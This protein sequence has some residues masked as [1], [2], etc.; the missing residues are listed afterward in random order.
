MKIAGDRSFAIFSLV[1]LA[2]SSAACRGGARAG[3]GGGPGTGGAGGGSGPGGTDAGSPVDSSSPGDATDGAASLSPDE[4]CRAA[5]EVQC[6]RLVTC[7][8]GGDPDSCIAESRGYAC[9]D[10]YFNADTE[11]TVANITACLADLANLPCTDVILGAR[12]ACF[13]AG[14]RAAGEGCAY[15]SQCRSGSCV[16][17]LTECG[18]CVV[19]AGSG[20]ACGTLETGAC[21]PGEFCHRTTKLCTP[22]GSIVHAA[23][24]QP[25]DLS[26]SPVVGCMGDLLCDTPSGATTTAGTCRP[27]PSAGQPCARQGGIASPICAP[28]A[29]CSGTTCVAS[30]PCGTAICAADSYCLKA[31]GGMTCVRRIAEGQPCDDPVAT[32]VEPCQGGTRCDR[33]ILI[34]ARLRYN[35][36]SCDA[37]HPCGGFLR[38]VDGR[39]QGIGSASCPVIPA[40]AGTD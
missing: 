27:A 7:R 17:G 31:D 15:A 14:K 38:C 22:N 40:D 25:C 26:A 35:G 34:C 10:Y 2:A 9:P 24:G 18:T 36:D 21:P 28:S 39:C 32:G 8:T 29:I 6:R 19:V 16:S 1:A 23:E 20:Q 4:A 33:T 12:A 13:A 37:T 30:S 5:I 11:R 3:T